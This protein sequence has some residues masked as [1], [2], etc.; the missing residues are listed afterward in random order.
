MYTQYQNMTYVIIEAAGHLIPYFALNTTVKMIEIFTQRQSNWNYYSGL[1]PTPVPKMM[2]DFANNCNG[3]G[4]CLPTGTCACSVGYGLADCSVKA[5]P[6]DTS[7][8]Y[9]INQRGFLFFSVPLNG[10]DKMVFFLNK[11]ILFT[12]LLDSIQE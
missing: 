10:K 3:N 8:T 5:V 2:C 12:N 11:L 9:T 1:T 6:L 7:K 4:Q